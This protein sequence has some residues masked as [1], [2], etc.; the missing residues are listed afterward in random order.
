MHRTRRLN[1]RCWLAAVAALAAMIAGCAPGTT[2]KNVWK[3][4]A[5]A[6]GP[7]K[8]AIVLG[9]VQTD[10]AR[11]TLED[12]FVAALVAQGIEATPSYTMF[13]GET[14]NKQEAREKVL[15]EG[16][17][18]VLV[19]KIGDKKQ[20]TT[21]MGGTSYWGGYHGGWGGYDSGTVMTTEYVSF[22]T[23][24]WDPS[25]EGTLVWS[26]GTETI[27]PN[28]GPKFAASLI[29]AVIPALTK[30]GILPASTKKY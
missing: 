12:A 17:D 5:W 13:P 30:D 27:N 21:Y 19:S 3:D 11:R 23:T 20:E 4:P 7:V 6:K 9:I 28:S 24:V 2:M 29:Q 8:K 22:E 16:F 15:A 18:A 1:S 25:K 10:G 14:I 26:G